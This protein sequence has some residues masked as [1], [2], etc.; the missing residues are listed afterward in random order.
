MK[1]SLAIASIIKT[2]TTALSLVQDPSIKVKNQ[3]D[4]KN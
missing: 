2:V 1:V 3:I 4:G